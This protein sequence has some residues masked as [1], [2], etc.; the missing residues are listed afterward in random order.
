MP[1]GVSGVLPTPYAGCL[2]EQAVR[3]PCKRISRK[4]QNSVEDSLVP[5]RMGPQHPGSW[6]DQIPPETAMKAQMVLVIKF[7]LPWIEL[8]IGVM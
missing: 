6:I 4:R 8:K 3:Y 1:N 7:E 2:G 5:R